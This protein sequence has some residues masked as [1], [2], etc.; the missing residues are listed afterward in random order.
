MLLDAAYRDLPDTPGEIPRPERFDEERRKRQVE[1]F[2]FG[3]Y[4]VREVDILLRPCDNIL[5]FMRDSRDEP[6][7]DGIKLLD[8]G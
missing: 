8:R 4:V 7:E 3:G 5:A 1:T 6:V 2:P